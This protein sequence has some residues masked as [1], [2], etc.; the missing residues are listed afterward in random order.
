MRRLLKLY[1]TGD[2]HLVLLYHFQGVTLRVPMGS[3]LRLKYAGWRAADGFCRRRV[4]V[5]LE[6]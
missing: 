6:E 5:V 1:V 4:E 2:L 3:V